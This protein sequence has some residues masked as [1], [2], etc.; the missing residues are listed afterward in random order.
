MFF[1]RIQPTDK[2]KKAADKEDPKREKRRGTFFSK[3][4]SSSRSSSAKIK[5]KPGEDLV[6]A[7]TSI[8]VKRSANNGLQ[9]F[10]LGVCEPFAFFKMY[11]LEAY[12]VVPQ[13]S[14]GYS[15][16]MGKSSLTREI[17]EVGCQPN[18][19]ILCS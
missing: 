6:E 12:R 10:E 9:L 2:A 5:L 1:I 3:R 14:R 7:T 13:M 16:T 17:A 8:Y 11:V 4:P 18:W 19:I 15:S